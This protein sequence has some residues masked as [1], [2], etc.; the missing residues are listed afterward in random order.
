MGWEHSKRNTGP[1]RKLRLRVRNLQWQTNEQG[2]FQR[3]IPTSWLCTRYKQWEW[4]IQWN[5]EITRDYD[6]KSLH[7]ER[8]NQPRH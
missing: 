5:S 4:S 7:L 6:S 1:K 2:K 3:Y 8:E